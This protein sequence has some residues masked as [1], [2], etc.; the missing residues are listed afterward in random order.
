VID[1]LDESRAKTVGQLGGAQ[2]DAHAIACALDRGWPLLTANPAP[3]T[4]CRDLG[5]DFEPLT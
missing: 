2:V 3:Y 1:N 4:S 5:V